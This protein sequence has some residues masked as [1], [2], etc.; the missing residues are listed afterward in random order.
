MVFLETYYELDQLLEGL[1]VSK[2]LKLL[3]R[4]EHPIS[5]VA[6]VSFLETAPTPLKREWHATTVPNLFLLPPAKH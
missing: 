3:S 4:V 1:D 5:A 2:Y 6:V